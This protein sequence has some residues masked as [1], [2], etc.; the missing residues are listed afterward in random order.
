[1]CRGIKQELCG[2]MGVCG[3]HILAQG[4]I[5]K[6]NPAGL[7]GAVHKEGNET[8]AS[9]THVMPMGPETQGSS[10]ANR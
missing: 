6:A 3:S 5:Q 9:G 8:H 1:M 4:H 10:D 2:A 7:G